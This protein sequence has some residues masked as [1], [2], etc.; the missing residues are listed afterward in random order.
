[1]FDHCHNNIKFNFYFYFYRLSGLENTLFGFTS[2]IHSVIWSNARN[3]PNAVDVVCFG[4]EY[5]F[6]HSNTI[7]K[8]CL[9]N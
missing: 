5:I 9:K 3:D 1:M 8:M 2:R 6:V 7:S 4:K